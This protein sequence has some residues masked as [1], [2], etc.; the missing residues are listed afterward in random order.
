MAALTDLTFEQFIEFQFGHAVR[1]QGNPWYF[2]TDGD[3]W[4]PEPRTGVA[5]LTRLFS[6]DHRC[7][8]G[9]A[10]PRLPKV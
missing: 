9:S 10:M 2:D 5:Y 1:P 8:S 7:C 4:W 3:W 6:E